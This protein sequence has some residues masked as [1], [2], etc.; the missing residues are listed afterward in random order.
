M[1]SGS[2]SGRLNGIEPTNMGAWSKYVL[3]WLNPTVLDY[4]SRKA[5]VT[6]GQASSPPKGTQEAVRVNLP[7]KKV[8]L[9]STHSGANAWWSNNDQD[10]GDQRL[11]RTIDVPTGS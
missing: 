2:R 1:S 9:G 6:L 11:T 7:D 5:S 8:T 3:G 10:Y 4:G